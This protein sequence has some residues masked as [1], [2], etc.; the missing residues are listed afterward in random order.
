MSTSAAVGGCKNC[1]RPSSASMACS[2]TGPHSVAAMRSSTI[3]FGSA[4]SKS[5]PV[6]VIAPEHDRV[7]DAALRR[8]LEDALI[9]LGLTNADLFQLLKERAA[10]LAATWRV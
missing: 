9:D 3:R 2:I 10:A 8:A 5:N 4:R 6:S 1:R 7:A